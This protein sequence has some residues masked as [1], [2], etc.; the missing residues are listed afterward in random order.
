[1]ATIA[2]APGR[3]SEVPVW[4]RPVRLTALHR[5]HLAHGA[6][7]VERD[8]WLLPA[9]YGDAAAEDAALHEAVGLLDIGESGKIDVKSDDLDAVLAALSQGGKKTKKGAPLPALSVSVVGDAVQVDRLTDGH[10]LIIT[11]PAA[12]QET[13]QT[14]KTAAAA[15]VCAH[16]TDVTSALCGLRLVGPQA[17]ALLERLAT[18][19]LA[20]NRFANGALAQCGLAKV[21]AIVARRDVAG[22]L[23]YDLYVDRDLGGYLWDALMEQGAPLGLKPVG[24]D[25]DISN[26]WPANLDHS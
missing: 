21:H 5:Q 11:A 9:T 19:D 25:I 6:T 12:L 13:M 2:T 20:P 24:R 8:G 15:S 16:V 14:L 7:M 26:Q 22:L 1:M 10:A 18:H 23:G 4:Q 17:P 3:A